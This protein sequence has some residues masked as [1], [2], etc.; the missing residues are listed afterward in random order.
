MALHLSDNYNDL[1]FKVATIKLS[2]LNGNNSRL[3]KIINSNSAILGELNSN[4]CNEI[5]NCLNSIP[6]IYKRKIAKLNAYE[7]FGY[8]LSDDDYNEISMEISGMIYEFLNSEN[9]II[10]LG[11]HVFRALNGNAIRFDSNKILLLCNK[12]LERKFTRWYE[13][14]IN[15]VSKINLNDVSD[16]LLEKFLDN[17]LSILLDDDPKCYRHN[18]ELENMIYIMVENNLS[19]HKS[20]AKFEELASSRLKNFYEH[21]YPYIKEEKYSENINSYIE[22]EINS[23]QNENKRQGENGVFFGVANN[24]FYKIRNIIEYKTYIIDYNIG[25]KIINTCID[26]LINS[27]QELRV[28]IDAMHLI[29]FI[30]YLN[31]DIKYEYDSLIE[32][33]NRKPLNFGK[34]IDFFDHTTVDAVEFDAAILKLALGLGN[35]NDLLNTITAINYKNNSDIISAIKCIE[36]LLNTS[37]IKQTSKEVLN[38]F[39]QFILFYSN[40]DN[41]EIRYQSIRTLTKMIDEGTSVRIFKRFSQ[42]MDGD[43]PSIKF[44][45]LNCCNTIKKFNEEIYDLILMKATIDNNYIIREK[46]KEII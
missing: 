35:G 25:Q 10:E 44:L 46:A 5:Y 19:S 39:M 13:D 30:K 37:Y 31:T 40:S 22:T 8:Y 9:S 2:L 21:D 12:A 16:D 36:N 28:K 24:H 17:I 33:L 18:R 26:T 43:I 7:Y 29:I 1:N 23:I 6:T 34:R 20:F 45:I 27:R 11:N 15:I 14:I 41:R 4:D 42:I 32:H 3:K 38:M